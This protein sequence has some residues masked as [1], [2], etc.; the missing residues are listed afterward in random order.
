MLGAPMI[1]RA[2]FLLLLLAA[3]QT[4]PVTGGAY[5]SPLGNDY[6]SQDKFVR[7]NYLTEVLL[8]REGG[9]LYEPEVVAAC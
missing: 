5:Y 3:C 1:P 7:E 8:T 9:L 4:D 6:K 2:P